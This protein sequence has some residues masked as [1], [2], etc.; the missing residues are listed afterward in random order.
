MEKNEKVTK[1]NDS[2]TSK[3][4]KI[5][6]AKKSTAKKNTSNKSKTSNSATTK[7]NTKSNIKSTKKTTVKK[8]SVKK[9]KNEAVD[10]IL[11]DLDK[12]ENDKTQIIDLLVSDQVKKEEIINS[13]ENEKV[14]KD[15]AFN[16]K[17]KRKKFFKGKFYLD[18]LDILIIILLTAIFSCIISGY[19]LNYQ[20]RKNNILYSTKLT[21]D[22]DLSEF[23][24]LYSNIKENYFEEVDT[25]GLIE[26]AI[27]GM[28]THLED[29]YSIYFNNESNDAFNDYLNGTYEGIGILSSANIIL[30]V[31]E[32][33]PAEAAGIE[34]GDVI[35]KVND[36]DI[37]SENYNMISEL[38]N[39]VEES[40]IV[41]KRSNKE[42]TFKIKPGTVTVN[43][44]TKKI[45]EK[46]G[47]KIGYLGLSSF[48][49]KSHEQFTEA[50]LDL[51]ESGI[52][53]LI[54]DLRGNSGGYLVSMENIASL[55]V[56]KGKTL[57]SLQSKDET[58][59][60]VDKTDDKRTYP[61]IVLINHNSASASEMLAACL[62]YSYGALIVGETSFGKGTAQ[63]VIHSGNSSFKYT[64]YKWL[65]PNGDCI[66]GIGLKPDYEVANSV[67]G[68]VVHDKQLDKALDLLS[69]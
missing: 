16:K 49:Y 54:I 5:S 56:E 10:V 64:A 4:K 21:E 65:T 17:S 31:Y 29:K 15:N 52:E 63:N 14:N 19:V 53:S 60:T 67:T 69:K 22:S 61:V 13:N 9:I 39:S 62:K 34:A 33:S 37:N 42:L 51:E 66:D 44:T 35:I 20:Y 28:V 7:S 30:E 25:K 26:A 32:D 58:I 48:T 27:D 59:E 11:N 36:V 2:S 3:V 46:S 50:L 41:V 47:K 57:Y 24:S 12:I 38:I 6:T 55:F 23:I 1:K 68:S 8:N 40:V 43:M 45:I 18:I